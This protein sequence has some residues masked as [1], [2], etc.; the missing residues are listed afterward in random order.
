[1]N[2]TETNDFQLDFEDDVDDMKRFKLSSL[3]GCQSKCSALF[4]SPLDEVTPCHVISSDMSTMTPQQQQLKSPPH[5]ETCHSCEQ[6]ILDKYLLHVS[7]KA[8]HT[9]CLRCSAC[10]SALGNQMTCFVGKDEQVYCKT[11]YLRLV[12]LLFFYWFTLPH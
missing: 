5:L 10:L 7:G 3:P 6:P 2:A 12:L 9:S 11:D 1:M 4:H 8:F